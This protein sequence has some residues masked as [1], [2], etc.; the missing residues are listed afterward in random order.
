MLYSTLY[1]SDTIPA[2]LLHYVNG[3]KWTD[4][5]VVNLDTSGSIG[6]SLTL[7]LLAADCG[8]GAHGGYVYLDGFGATLPPG[9]NGTVP[10]PA[11]LFVLGLGLIG[12]VG[13]R[14]K[15]KK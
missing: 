15:F 3:W 6:H 2:N 10:E 9:G 11:T 14:K 8:Q 4:W 13:F 12:L 1:A 5:Q 7:T